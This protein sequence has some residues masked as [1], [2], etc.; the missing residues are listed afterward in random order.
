M[1][2]LTPAQ[3]ALLSAM[4]AAPEWLL[5]R[6]ANGAWQVHDT[7]TSVALERRYSERTVE[8]LCDAGYLR[9]MHD[10]SDWHALVLDMEA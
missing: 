3:R 2:A 8:A 6:Q 10:G 4:R 1:T 7:R 5:L 9:Q